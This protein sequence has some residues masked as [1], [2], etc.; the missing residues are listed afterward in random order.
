MPILNRLQTRFQLA[1]EQSSIP[2]RLVA[3]ESAQHSHAMN[4]AGLIAR[5]SAVLIDKFE[6]MQLAQQRLQTGMDAMRLDL[7]EFT[8]ST[9][10]EADRQR[11]AV[12]A[13]ASV[14]A[15][16]SEAV[17][18]LLAATSAT[19]DLAT[20]VATA[21]TAATVANQQ[22]LART[23]V[24]LERSALTLGSDVLVHTPAGFLLVPAEDRTLLAA[25]WESGGRLEP[26]TVRVLTSLLREG[27]HSIDVGAHIGLTV[28]PAARKVG[29][30]GRVLAFEP[31]SRVAA[32]LRQ[33]VALNFL[34][35]RVVV[36]QCAAGDAEGSAHIHLSPI[37]GESSLLDLPGSSATEE[38]EVRTV[39][40]LVA[41][42]QVIRLVKIDAEGFEPQVWKGMRRVVDDNPNLIVIVE[43]GPTHLARAGIDIADWLREFTVLGFAPMEIDELSGIIRPLRSTALLRRVGSLN[44]LM[45][46]Q[47]PTT[48]SL[49]LEFE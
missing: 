15:A 46:R 27:D 34:T 17:A 33:S 25:V 44:I 6:S 18:S 9:A 12:A 11:E 5:D 19:A 41:P 49:E 10:A 47:P 43:F 24:L 2:H 13:S 23:D 36:H 40:S 37:L 32:L 8:E 21:S 35:D 29:S 26:G 16:T 20:S 4:L 42:G 39:D 48:F 22:L 14:L 30:S 3:I 31:L 1:V 38:V 7:S 45:L 28:I